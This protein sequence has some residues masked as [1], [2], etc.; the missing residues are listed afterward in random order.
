MIQL[1]PLSDQS[2]TGAM[3]LTSPF[4]LFCTQDVPNLLCSFRKKAL[5]V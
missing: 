3:K 5:I 2:V 1:L 4:D